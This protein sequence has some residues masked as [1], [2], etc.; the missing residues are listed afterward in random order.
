MVLHGK[1]IKLLITILMVGLSSAAYSKD[2][3]AGKNFTVIHSTV[4]ATAATG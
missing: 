2:Y 4:T 3:Q 1:V